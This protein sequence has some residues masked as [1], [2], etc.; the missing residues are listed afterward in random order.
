MGSVTFVLHDMQYLIR[1]G[2][3]MSVHYRSV[4]TNGRVGGH[5]DSTLWTNNNHDRSEDSSDATKGRYVSSCPP[6]KLH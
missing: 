2:M 1:Q 5:T 3:D 4:Q 6:K